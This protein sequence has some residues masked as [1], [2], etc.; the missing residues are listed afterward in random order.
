MLVF[1][2]RL[3]VLAD[4]SEAGWR[5]HTRSN[6]EATADAEMLAAPSYKPIPCPSG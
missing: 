3:L 4:P 5:V 6:A 2:P 1:G